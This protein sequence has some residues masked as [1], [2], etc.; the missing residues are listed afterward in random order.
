V[1]SQKTQGQP[2][3]VFFQKKEGRNRAPNGPDPKKGH[4]SIEAELG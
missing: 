1:L 3:E 2:G 4:P